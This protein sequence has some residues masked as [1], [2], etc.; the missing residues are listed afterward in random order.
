MKIAIVGSGLMG[1]AIAW[2]L[3]EK[4][5]CAVTLFDSTGIGAGSSGVAAG[6]MHPYPGE[7]ARRSFLATQ[8]IEATRQLLSIAQK[9]SLLPLACEQ[10]ILRLPQTQ[11]AHAAL[12]SHAKTYKDV[13]EQGS[14]FLI[15]CGMTIFCRRYLDS[16]W[17]AVQ[18]R[19]GEFKQQKIEDLAELSSYD[20]IVLALGAGIKTF[21][22]TAF[23]PLQLLKGQVLFCRIPEP[24]EIPSYSLIGK[25]YIAKAAD[26]RLCYLGATYERHES[27]TNIDRQRAERELLP[28]IASFYPDAANF[29]ILECRA[30]FRV[31]RI[32]HYCPFLFRLNKSVW[33]ATALGSRGL[34]YHGLLAEQ[35][36]SALLADDE[37]LISKEFK[38]R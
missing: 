23:L 13:E 7:E 20:H 11:Q 34:L 5:E 9:K 27:S 6:L 31:M 25:G 26:E 29:E 32:G 24:L 15:R 3:I 22:E 36:S 19:G 21:K 17:S 16:L 10:G 37:A 33:V 38:L 2:H 30:A 18:Q 8:G 35:L 14:F 4:A 28:K 1:L 12:I